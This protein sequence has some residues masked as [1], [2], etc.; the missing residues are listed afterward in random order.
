MR[1]QGKV[2]DASGKKLSGV[3]VKVL[4]DGKEV[5][6]SVTGSN[7][8]YQPYEAYYGYTYKV[9]FTKDGLVTKS[10]EIN[11]KDNFFEEDVEK[12]I[13]IP[14]EMS[15][16]NK[17]PGIDYTPIE[18]K[19]VGRFRIDKNTGFMDIDFPFVNTRKKE[20]EDFFK[21]IADETKN[22]DKRFND[23]VKA[24][25]KSFKKKGYED[26]IKNWKSALEIKDDSD[27][28]IKITDAEMLLDES[29]EAAAIDEKFNN[30]IK[31]GDNLLASNKFDEAIAKYNQAQ[32]VKPKDKLPKEK[33]EDVNNKRNQLEADKLDKEYNDLMSQ[34]NSFKNKKEYDK[35]IESY[36]K[37]KGVKPKEREP[38]QQIKAINDLIAKAAENKVKYDNLITAGN[39]LFD[40]KSY[41]EARDKYEEALELIPNETIPKEKIKE[42]NK[43]LEDQEAAE[44]AEKEKKEKYKS[45]ISKADDQL[46]DKNY[47]S[48]KEN[49][50]EALKLYPTESYPKGK[51]TEIDNLIKQADADYNKLIKEGD[52]LLADK[53]F[54]EAIK[55]YELA[56]NIKKNEA[57]PKNQ[58]KKANELWGEAKSKELGEKRKREEY[59]KLI[60][61]GN[62]F[63]RGKEYQNAKDK[64][65]EASSLIPE[66]QYP[67]DQ[68]KLIDELLAKQDK[69]YDD[70]IASADQ[71]LEAG[72]LETAIKTYED[73]LLVKNDQYPKDQIEKA[74]KLL[75][76]KE[77]EAL[78]AQELEEKYKKLKAEADRELSNQNFN[79]ARDKYQEALNLKPKEEEPKKQIAF[80]DE[81]IRKRKERYDKY[82]SEA[83]QLFEGEKFEV[84]IEKYEE[85]LWIL[86]VEQ[87]PKD[88]IELAR[89]RLEDTKNN[90]LAE[91]DKDKKYQEFINKGN[92]SLNNQNYKD[93]KNQYNSALNLK[94]NEQYPKDQLA[95]IEQKLKELADKESLANKEA[96][97]EKRYKDLIGRADQKFENE[98]YL[99][100]KGLY[101]EALTIKREQYPIN[102]ISK[103]NEKLTELNQAEELK[104]QYKKIIEVADQKFASKEYEE[105]KDLYKRAMKFNPGAEYPAL[106]IV[107]I[108]K[109]L[110]DIAK[111]EKLKEVDEARKNIL[112][113][114][115]IN[116]GDDNFGVKK[117]Q[118]ARDN[119]VEASNLKPSETYPKEKIAELDKIL[120]E[121]KGETEK[122][123]GLSSDYFEWDAK[124]YGDEVDIDEGDVNLIITKTQDNREYKNYL[125]VR[126]YI[127]SMYTVDNKDVERNINTTY[128]SYRDYERIKEVIEKDNDNAD[129]TRQKAITSFEIF[130]E[131]HIKERKDLASDAYN[132]NGEIAEGITDF[133]EARTREHLSGQES[134]EANAKNYERLNDRFYKENK[135]LKDNNIDKTSEIY[136]ETTILKDNLIE[137][138]EDGQEKIERNAA[139]YD[140]LNN[141][142]YR[143]NKNLQDENID[144]TSE[145]YDQITDLKEEL[146]DNRADGQESIEANAKNYEILNDRFYDEKKDK[147]L[148][149]LDFQAELAGQIDDLKER[150]IKEHGDGQYTIEL[151]AKEYEKLNDRFAEE[152]INDRNN[153]ID[154]TSEI[155]DQITDFKEEL[156]DDHAKGQ[157]SIEANAENYERLNNRFYQENKD[158]KDNNI[159][160]TSE[161]YNQTTALKDELIANHDDGQEKIEA[162]AEVYENYND[163][164]KKLKN[165]QSESQYRAGQEVADDL[166][167][168]KEKI[169]AENKAADLATEN[170]AIVYEN[171][172]DRLTDRN[173]YFTD[174]NTDDSYRNAQDYEYT[175]DN[176]SKKESDDVMNQLA[177]IFPEGVTQ[178]IYQRKN[179]DG[180][181]TEITVRRIVV[182]GNKGNQYRK[183]TNRSG[184]YYFKNGQPI[185]DS[186]WDI[187]T[188]GDIV[189]SDE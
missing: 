168:L 43:L 15:M 184:T 27:L 54:E 152:A 136:N 140:R 96:D 171:L 34:A 78:N 29:K 174:K 39:K 24:G 135:N 84:S 169:N 183:T 156:S 144:K 103:I 134:I 141:R 75:A 111:N 19:P 69:Q 17:E 99:D 9:I 60:N 33:I 46:R 148:E 65:K 28:R 68:I 162:N 85:A 160:K 12:E 150:L 116:T 67:K 159:D 153:N 64:F 72:E 142:F 44:K 66:E 121:L 167:K 53:K 117:Y 89:K 90:L 110:A 5:H 145:I 139:N 107:E 178:K 166:D 31:E 176:L 181:V 6:S 102:Q 82:I 23:L 109:I 56:S 187:E 118:I 14:I 98:K 8:R 128:L 154:K 45:L 41:K 61:Q 55:S 161:V 83:D 91:A 164:L 80:I 71:Q 92:R 18:G 13:A 70:L 146:V 155:Y 74:K 125:R 126:N 149:M 175:K 57:Y 157:E 35:A 158:L 1:F 120:A 59:E 143:E 42:I 93:A 151:N 185:S 26:A 179:P 147:N 182:R 173:K 180:E 100:A 16:I 88:Q 106:K 76:D 38:D 124:A 30:L 51:L 123:K 79:L 77:K 114:K 172:N 62:Q 20:I 101:Q 7:G 119:Y 186:T 97:K 104:K 129:K 11:S 48:A 87:Y 36:N 188:S 47:E 3:T 2:S 115:L 22:K 50:K 189:N 132:Y 58:I 21:K 86:P 138:H 163:K 32:K 105:A 165:N 94:P 63:F 122:Y 4:R 108:D 127:D 73:A 40:N 133:K 95:L 37:A 49:F 81:M 177:L 170:N 10:V 112:Y 52:Q 130:R 113:Q 131:Y 25:D 137:N